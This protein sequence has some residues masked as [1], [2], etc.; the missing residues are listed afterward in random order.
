MN[1][2][3]AERAYVLSLPKRVLAALPVLAGVCHGLVGVTLEQVCADQRDVHQID[4]HYKS[5]DQRSK[6]GAVSVLSSQSLT[7][8]VLLQVPGIDQLFQALVANPLHALAIQ[9][10]PATRREMP[11]HSTAS[12]F[13]GCYSVSI[14]PPR[15]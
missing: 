15:R 14:G 9:G 6:A 5:A 7:Q 4:L 11:P 1:R 3:Q 8:Q 2:Q 13:F 12:G 10:I